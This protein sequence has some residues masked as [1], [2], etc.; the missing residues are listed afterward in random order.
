MVT[1]H[2][3]CPEDDPVECEVTTCKNQATHGETWGLYTYLL[4]KGCLATQ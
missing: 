4:C 3:L 1:V 2:E